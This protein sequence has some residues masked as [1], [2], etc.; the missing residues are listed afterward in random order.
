MSEI[1][2]IAEQLKSFIKT[3][4]ILLALVVLFYLGIKR[5]WFWLILPPLGLILLRDVCQVGFFTSVS[6]VS[7]ICGWLFI[8]SLL[9]AFSHACFEN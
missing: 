5:I 1:E 6:N 7:F 3:Y 9:R 2:S 4:G 8:F